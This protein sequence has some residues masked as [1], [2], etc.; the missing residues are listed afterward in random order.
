[1]LDLLQEGGD[2][3]PVNVRLAGRGGLA[4]D[5]LVVGEG[6][7]VWDVLEEA[8]AFAEQAETFLCTPVEIEDIALWEEAPAMVVESAGV[9]IVAV[10]TDLD[11]RKLALP[12]RLEHVADLVLDAPGK[13]RD[14]S[15]HILQHEESLRINLS[16]ADKIRVDVAEETTPDFESGARQHPALECQ[17]VQVNVLQARRGFYLDDVPEVFGDWSQDVHPAISALGG[18]RSLKQRLAELQRLLGQPN[19]LI[20]VEDAV[21]DL[22]AVREQLFGQSTHLVALVENRLGG[23]VRLRD[24]VFGVEPVPEEFLT[25]KTYEVGGF[26]NQRVPHVGGSANGGRFP[27][28]HQPRYHVR[29]AL[30]N[31]FQNALKKPPYSDPVLMRKFFLT[32]PY[33][34][35]F[36]LYVF[37][38]ACEKSLNGV[39]T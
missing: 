9:R 8:H 37:L 25:L 26:G 15:R 30:K 17:V 10:W 2:G 32:I 35:T 20:E 28:H 21:A 14:L 4:L 39:N 18:D 29:L 5:F 24:Q 3:G 22:R 1:M 12:D 23:F 34:Q 7:S 11:V 38:F 6:E 19:R 33:N 31:S 16:F 36:G 27:I 13:G